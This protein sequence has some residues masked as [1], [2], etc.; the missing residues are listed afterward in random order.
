MNTITIN[1][2]KYGRVLAAAVNFQLIVLF[3]DGLRKFRK[4]LETRKVC[5]APD[6]VP[7]APSPRSTVARAKH[8][9]VCFQVYEIDPG[10]PMRPVRERTAVKIVRGPSGQTRVYMKQNGSYSGEEYRIFGSGVF[11]TF[12]AAKKARLGNIAR[13]LLEP[14]RQHGPGQS[15]HILRMMGELKNAG[16]ENIYW[17]KEKVNGKDF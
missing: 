14:Y 10:C 4:D 6:E 12:E 7:P 2:D 13:K 1:G 11:F 9:D 16:M 15:D 5:G 3:K 8:Q 17:K